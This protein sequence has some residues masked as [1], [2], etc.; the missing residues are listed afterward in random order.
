MPYIY[1]EQRDYLATG[2]CARNGGEVNYLSTLLMNSYFTDYNSANEIATAIELTI[3]KLLTNKDSVR[4]N[5]QSEF[6]QELV[7]I[8]MNSAVDVEEVVGALR[9]A[10][11]EFY[12]RKVRPYEILK[13]EENGDV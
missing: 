5:Y 6:H 13:M 3:F 4:L 8:V 12:A 9:N 11:L 1:K 7:K 10:H 2:Q